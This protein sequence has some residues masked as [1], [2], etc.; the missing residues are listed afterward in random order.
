[1]L[2]DVEIADIRLEGLSKTKE[3]LLGTSLCWPMLESGFFRIQMR[4]V[5]NWIYPFCLFAHNHENPVLG[6]FIQTESRTV[7]LP[8]AGRRVPDWAD[9][10]GLFA[11]RV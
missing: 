6:S 5:T 2:L 4:L 3:G 1:M 11:W 9:L 10:L 7:Y 8:Y